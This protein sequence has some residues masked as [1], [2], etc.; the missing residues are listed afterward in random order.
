MEPASDRNAT[1]GDD[2]YDQQTLKKLGDMG[3]TM[4]S[5]VTTREGARTLEGLTAALVFLHTQSV[6]SLFTFDPSGDIG[7]DADHMVLWFNQATPGFP[8][9]VPNCSKRIRLQLYQAAV[10]R[11]LSILD[12]GS[13]SNISAL[14]KQVAKFENKVAQA[15]LNGYFVNE[16]FT[17]DSRE[18]ATT[19]ISNI[20][21]SFTDSLAH[22]DWMDEESAKATAEK[23]GGIQELMSS[24]TGDTYIAKYYDP[25]QI[26]GN[27]YFHSVLNAQFVFPSTDMDPIRTESLVK[28]TSFLRALRTGSLMRVWPNVQVAD[29]S[30]SDEMQFK[31]AF[32]ASALLVAAT[33]ALGADFVWFSGASCTGSVIARSPGVTPGICVFLTNGGSAK[34]ISYSGVPNHANFFESGG[35]HD[36]CTNGPTIVTGGGS[37]CAT[38]PAGV[39]IN[40]QRPRWSWSRLKPK[41]CI[42]DDD[43]SGSISA[44]AKRVVEFENK[45]AQATLN[46]AQLKD[47][48]ATYNPFSAAE[49]FAL[50]LQIDFPT[51]FSSFHPQAFP[52]RIIVISPSYNQNLYQVLAETFDDVIEPRLVFRAGL[53]LSTLLGMGM[54]AWQVQRS[55]YNALIGSQASTVGGCGEYCV[56]RIINTLRFAMGRYFVNEAFTGDSRERTTVIVSNIV[57]AFTDSLAHIDWM[58]EESAKAAAAKKTNAMKIQVGYP[59][60]PNT[61]SS[62][63]IA[64]YYGPVEID[65]NDYF[66][67]VL[68]AQMG[69]RFPDFQKVEENRDPEE[70]ILM[71]P[72]VVNAFY[73]PTTN[74]ITFPAGILQS[75]FFSRACRDT[76]YTVV[77]AL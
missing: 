5:G 67:S 17:D 50:L 16:A 8:A 36:V 20:V 66:H 47:P 15:S 22:I 2:Q 38:A 35:Q 4:A 45:V 52:S 48:I 40:A 27:D 57:K 1:T 61:T 23:V 70:W 13:S 55:L 21:K 11:L 29:P 63:Y 54:E 71:S 14:A 12:D 9:K 76:F 53:G 68:N 42:L 18:R 73:N 41:P 72:P 39:Q 49:F 56:S 44:L 26:D 62:Q 64:E 34:S 31:I 24:S 3:N 19:I 65:G 37:G 77:S 25:V 59:L 60:S 58:D 10:E 75:S 7:D 51:C 74:D 6:T 28:L 46:G 32:L 69:A 30:V 43:N 33:P